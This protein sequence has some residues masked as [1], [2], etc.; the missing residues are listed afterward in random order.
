MRDVCRQT[1]CP[2]DAHRRAIRAFQVR[3]HPCVEPA[4]QFRQMHEAD[5]S[6]IV[7]VLHEISPDDVV[8]IRDAFRLLR[9]RREKHAW[10]FDPAKREHV[11]VGAHVELCLGER[12]ARE[13]LDLS[14]ALIEPNVGDVGV[15]NHANVL[16]LLESPAIHT[17]KACRRAELVVAMFDRGARR[18]QSRSRGFG[19]CFGVPLERADLE[20]LARARIPRQEIGIANRPTAVRDVVSSARNPGASTAGTIPPSAPWSHRAR[21]CASSACSTC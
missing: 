11:P 12:A 20:R 15:R 9:S 10:V 18:Q 17:G 4:I 19:A 21:G 8:G 13:G 1:K 14:A 3:R 7:R 16:G 5:R 6:V 2:H